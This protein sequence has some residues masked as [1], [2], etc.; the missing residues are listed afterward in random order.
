MRKAYATAARDAT[1]SDEVVIENRRAGAFPCCRANT[2]NR[3]RERICSK[4]NDQFAASVHDSS[5]TGNGQEFE[6]FYWLKGAAL[7]DDALFGR[8]QPVLRKASFQRSFPDSSS[9]MMP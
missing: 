7:C 2:P 5:F 8:D 6:L 3:P 1:P 9:W 4:R